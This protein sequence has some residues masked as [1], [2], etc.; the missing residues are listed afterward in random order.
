MPDRVPVCDLCKTAPRRKGDSIL[1]HDCADEISRVM[2]SEIYE[3]NYYRNRQAQLA[4]ARLQ[5]CFAKDSN[6]T[7]DSSQGRGSKD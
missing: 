4:Q 5:M 7:S 2:S 3:A 6:T 1:C